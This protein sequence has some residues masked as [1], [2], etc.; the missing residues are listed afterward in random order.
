M[1]LCSDTVFL[2]LTRVAQSSI[3]YVRIAHAGMKEAQS[4]ANKA[5]TGQPLLLV[6]HYIQSLLS[7]N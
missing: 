7:H 3:M 5:Y 1:K 2:A 6:I 4:T